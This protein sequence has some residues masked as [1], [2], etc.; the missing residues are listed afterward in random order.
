[1]SNGFTVNSLAKL[2][3][4]RQLAHQNLD[5]PQQVLASKRIEYDFKVTGFNMTT[6]AVIA[7]SAL[8]IITGLVTVFVLAALTYNVRRSFMKAVQETAL[9]PPRGGLVD[10]DLLLRV[11]NL[12]PE[13]RRNE[14]AADLEINDPNW[15]VIQYQLLDFKVWMNWVPSWAVAPRPAAVPPAAG[16]APAGVP[17]Q[18]VEGAP[19]GVPAQPAN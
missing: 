14:I 6:A 18:A 16:G 3:G 15:Q 2:Y 11:A 10:P 8:A 12:N 7:A 4:D 5:V 9:L 1:M 17:V 13:Q 19:I